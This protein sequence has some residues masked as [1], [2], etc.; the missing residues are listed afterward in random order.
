ML[1]WSIYA[2]RLLIAK[3]NIKVMNAIVLFACKSINLANQNINCVYSG[4]LHLFDCNFLFAFPIPFLA[5][6]LKEVPA[7]RCRHCW[8]IPAAAAAAFLLRSAFTLPANRFRF[9]SVSFAHTLDFWLCVCVSNKLNINHY[10]GTYR[11]DLTCHPNP[12]SPLAPTTAHFSVCLC[13]Y[14]CSFRLSFHM[15]FY[16]GTHKIDF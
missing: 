11:R 10:N 4:L 5:K 1:D 14:I 7:A 12:Q 9:G 16:M 2:K 13:L 8:L 15:E 6:K 3:V